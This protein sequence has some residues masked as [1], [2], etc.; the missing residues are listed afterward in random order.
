MAR[1]PMP[2]GYT[3]RFVGQVD[4]LDQARSAL[5]SALM[6]SIILIYMLLVALY[7]SWLHPLAIMF[8]LP[9]AMVGAFGGLLLTG[10]TFNLFSMI[11]IIMLMGIVA[12]NAILL[13]DFTNTLRERGLARNAAILE[14]G[15]TRLRPIVMTTATIVFAMFPLALKLEEGA[16]SR[17][18]MAIV[19]IGGV[20]TSTLLTL[21]LVPVMYSYLD[22][23]SRLPSLARAK[24][25]AW[26]RLRNLPLPGLGARPQPQS[27]SGSE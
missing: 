7:E 21:V 24:V 9:V 11:G 27:A 4:Q 13:V 18:P 2:S 15:P 6:I 20:I 19:L 17:A 12:K 23:L 16:E 25:P 8:S 5:L 26:L 14:A 22:D 10:N 3:W 1:L